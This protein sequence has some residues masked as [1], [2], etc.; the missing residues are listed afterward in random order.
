MLGVQVLLTYSFASKWKKVSEFVNAKSVRSDFHF[1]VKNGQ[2]KSVFFP[3]KQCCFA[4]QQQDE[5][6]EF[7]SVF[8]LNSIFEFSWGQLVGKTCTNHFLS[9]LDFFQTLKKSNFVFLWKK[10]NVVK[11]AVFSKWKVLVHVKLIVSL[12]NL[13]DRNAGGA[14]LTSLSFC[15]KVKKSVWVC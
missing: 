8:R 15:V 11:F 12:F 4:N 13:V 3:K 1:A 6:L 2:K 9:F 7:F 14:S 5:D 10:E